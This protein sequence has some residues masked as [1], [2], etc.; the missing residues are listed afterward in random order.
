MKSYQLGPVKIYGP[1]IFELVKS[2]T[3]P[4]IIRNFY[5][6]LRCVALR[7]VTLNHVALH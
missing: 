5:F 2:G 1:L 4:Y 6:A 3:G 7:Y